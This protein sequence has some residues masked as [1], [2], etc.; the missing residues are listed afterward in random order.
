MTKTVER[1][2]ES[3]PATLAAQ[4]MITGIG[5]RVGLY[6]MLWREFAATID[7]NCPPTT[8][9]VV[10]LVPHISKGRRR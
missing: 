7:W 6:G 5:W 1:V 3:G 9:R 8:R 10:R 2:L 4:Q